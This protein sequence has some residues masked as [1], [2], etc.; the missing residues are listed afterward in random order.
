MKKRSETFSDAFTLVE[1][2]VVIGII[3][4]LVAMLLPALN[5]VRQQAKDIVCASNMRQTLMA[6]QLYNIAYKR[7]LQNY[8]PK[9][10]WWGAGWQHTPGNNPL[11]ESH[12][13]STALSDGT[14]FFHRHMEAVGSG[15]YWRG[16]LIEAGLLGKRD[17]AGNVISA[18]VLGC[19]A[20]DFTDDTTFVACYNSYG[21]ANQLETSDTQASFRK[22]PAYNW[23]GS[24][25]VRDAEIRSIIGGH[26]ADGST[27]IYT[28]YK[29][30]RALLS[31][32]YPWT[33]PTPFTLP[34]ALVSTHRSKWTHYHDSGGHPA[35]M[36][37]AENVGYTDGSVRFFQR[38]DGPWGVT[39]DPLR[40]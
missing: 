4:I 19:P 34:R 17:T 15:T 26:L 5:K 13:L 38:R 22:N 30:R 28:G 27:A 29:K 3:A 18:D 9:C 40:D 6:V 7:G 1:L 12:W 10:Q 21:S 31:C 11:D 33:G 35:G 16:Y 25:G 8:H 37:Y 32:P 36:R 39:F 14:S 2:L 23:W 20:N 24:G